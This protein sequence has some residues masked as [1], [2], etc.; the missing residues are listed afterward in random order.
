MS[1]QVTFS[2]QQTLSRLIVQG[3]TL[4][5]MYVHK[6]IRL[7]PKSANPKINLLSF[8][9]HVCMHIVIDFSSTSTMTIEIFVGLL[10]ITISES[11][12]RNL[13]T[14]ITVLRKNRSC[15]CI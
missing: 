4:H 9:M 6:Y 15:D 2:D 5:Y 12:Y 11:N 1:T 14:R 7:R 13:S 3:Q 8:K 10:I